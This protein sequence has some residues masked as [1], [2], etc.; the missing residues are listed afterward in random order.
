MARCRISKISAFVQKFSSCLPM[1][2]FRQLFSFS[3]TVCSSLIL[4]FTA[5]FVLSPHNIAVFPSSSLPTA[6]LILLL[7]V[8]GLKTWWASGLSGQYNIVD[9]CG[10]LSSIL[11]RL[12]GNSSPSVILLSSRRISELIAGLARVDRIISTFTADYR[13][14][15]FHELFNGVGYSTC[16]CFS[17]K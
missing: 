16:R 11:G 3:C 15:S 5:C 13:T 12:F 14:L 9:C 10:A 2:M 4:H 17:V 6:V 1:T 8:L 7:V